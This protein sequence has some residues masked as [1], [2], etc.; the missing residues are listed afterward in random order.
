[1]RR[2]GYEPAI[3]VFHLFASGY[4]TL[5]LNHTDLTQSMRGFENKNDL[6]SSEECGKKIQQN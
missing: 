3:F 6:Y 4:P 5:K 2:A 1:M